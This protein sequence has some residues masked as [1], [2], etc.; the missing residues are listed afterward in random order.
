MRYVRTGRGSDCVPRFFLTARTT[1]QAHGAAAAAASTG[2]YRLAD[3]LKAAV[4]D[5]SPD[6]LP[7][8]QR[9][10]G[11]TL[12]TQVALLRNLH[13]HAWRQDPHRV[14]ARVLD[15]TLYPQD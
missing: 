8:E 9:V 14:W 12:S 3:L 4:V 2:T 13:R 15:D 5:V 1:L 6:L 11:Q 7:G 10:L